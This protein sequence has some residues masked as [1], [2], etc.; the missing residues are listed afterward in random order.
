MQTSESKD[1]W[2]LYD[3]SAHFEP[4]VRDQTCLT[5]CANFGF[6]TQLERQ[7][8]LDHKIVKT[9]C[10]DAGVAPKERSADPA[11]S[12]DPAQATASARFSKGKIFRQKKTLVP[13]GTRVCRRMG[14][15]LGAGG[16]S[17][18][19]WLFNQE[20]RLSFPILKK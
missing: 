13:E 5:V 11:P 8:R 12:P 19:R 14:E 20:P 4:E 9:R 18:R 7:R 1:H 15:G 3:S 6:Q 2:Q 16:H 10:V 17:T